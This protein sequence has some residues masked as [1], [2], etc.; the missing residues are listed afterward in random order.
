MKLLSFFSKIRG[1]LRKFHTYSNGYR[2]QEQQA[3]NVDAG[4]SGRQRQDTDVRQHLAGAVQPGGD[5][6][7]A[8][9]RRPGQ[10]DHKLGCQDRRQQGNYQTKKRE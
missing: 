9:V 4:Q 10:T 3:H 2:L 1:I 7:L 6:H 8:H 5:A